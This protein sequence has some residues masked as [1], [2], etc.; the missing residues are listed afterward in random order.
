MLVAPHVFM[1][2]STLIVLPALLIYFHGSGFRTRIA[3]TLFFVPIPYLLQL[4]DKPW[5]MAPSLV[6]SALL[7][8][9]LL[10]APM[11]RQIRTAF[12][13]TPTGTP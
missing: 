2:D 6:V 11:L 1:Y 5:T 9:L 3:A 12:V 7:I 8:S 4:A 10:E 13:T